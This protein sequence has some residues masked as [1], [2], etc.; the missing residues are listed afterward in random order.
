MNTKFAAIWQRV[1]DLSGQ[2]FTTVSGRQFSYH[3]HGH[4]VDMNTTNRTLPR[5]DFQK[6]FDRF[7]VS[8]PG[9]LHDLQGPSYIYSILMDPRVRGR[10][11]S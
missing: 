4:D 11:G 3:A 9:A 7:P 10:A 5:S 2:T 8:G 6:A 1:Q